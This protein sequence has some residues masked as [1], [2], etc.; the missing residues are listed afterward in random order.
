MVLAQKYLQVLIFVLGISSP[1]FSQEIQINEDPKVTQLLKAWVNENRSDP[2]IAGWRVQ[3]M[4]ST[5]RQEVE[6]GRTRFRTVYPDVSANSVQEKPYYKLRVGAFRT[7]QEA[8]AFIS[9]LSG[10]QGAYPAK[11]AHIHP[12]DFL[13]Q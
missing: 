1:V 7:K 10:W 2:Q 4:A 5:D 9:E 6:Q 11:D 12:R 8:L 13:E 3:I